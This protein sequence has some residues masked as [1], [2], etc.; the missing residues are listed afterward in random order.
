MRINESAFKS[1]ESTEITC[2]ATC[3]VKLAISS[4]EVAGLDATT[5]AG[6]ICWET[7]GPL[8]AAA[9]FFFN[10]N[11]SATAALTTD[12]SALVAFN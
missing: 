5:A 4:G 1:T 12:F 3:F 8:S 9:N 10:S 6:G 2:S 7:A 11:N